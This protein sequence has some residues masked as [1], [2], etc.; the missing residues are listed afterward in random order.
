M[1]SDNLDRPAG[2]VNLEGRLER[3]YRNP[4][5]SPGMQEAVQKASITGVEGLVQPTGRKRSHSWSMSD[6]M[7]AALFDHIDHYHLSPIAPNIFASWALFR[8]QQT[9]AG[10]KHIPSY[11]QFRRAVK[12]LNRNQELTKRRRS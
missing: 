4:R 12:Q 8:H 6:D 5:K 1:P 7:R 10:A 3:H 2:S 11:D 9:E